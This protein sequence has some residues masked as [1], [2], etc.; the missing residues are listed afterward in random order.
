MTTTVTTTTVTTVT[1]MGFTAAL[2][3]V[4]TLALIALLVSKELGGASGNA[5]TIRWSQ[6]LNVGI[7]PLLFAF[8]VIVLEK[9]VASLS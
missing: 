7:L 8:G 5:G 1:V 2:G 3:V 6:V 4:A 9:I